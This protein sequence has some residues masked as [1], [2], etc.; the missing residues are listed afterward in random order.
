MG[1][2][3]GSFDSDCLFDSSSEFSGTLL[4]LTSLLLGI[5][6]RFPLLFGGENYLSRPTALL[7]VA[8]PLL[9]YIASAAITFIT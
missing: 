6:K 9:E 8:S 7:G 5:P 2:L 1:T 4:C 3:P